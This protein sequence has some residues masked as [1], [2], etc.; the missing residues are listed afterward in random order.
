MYIHLM[1]TGA[2][3]VI[4]LLVAGLF[5]MQVM[6]AETG[7]Q[8]MRDVA[9]AIKEGALAFLRRQYTTIAVI[10]V[11]TALLLFGVYYLTGRSDLAIPT[12]AAFLFGAALSGVAGIIGM[13]TSVHAN[14]R[15]AAAAQTSLGKAI[16]V[17]LRGGAVSG[18]TIVALSLLGVSIIF[19]ALGG[20]P[21]TTPR[22]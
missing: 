14:L 10:G 11:V 13:W 1:L 3:G 9:A 2:I 17:A 20:D 21:Q 16:V 22:N 4:A 19:T 8:G 15:S 12:A 5:A 18:L 7:T 6:R